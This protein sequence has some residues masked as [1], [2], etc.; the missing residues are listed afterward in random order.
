M[1][2]REWKIV[3][4]RHISSSAKI[5]GTRDGAALPYDA[6]TRMEED[7]KVESGPKNRKRRCA[8]ACRLGTICARCACSIFD[9]YENLPFQSESHLGHCFAVSSSGQPG[10]AL[11][12]S[13]Y[14]SV[15]YTKIVIPA[16]SSRCGIISSK[17]RVEVTGVVIQFLVNSRITSL[18]R[19]NF[20]S[21]LRNGR[22]DTL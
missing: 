19:L 16:L 3:R 9:S 1:G 12:S 20:G 21:A 4:E 13:P 22:K 8:A 2:L 6:R 11:F 7:S 17:R 10:D 14:R 5:G 15:A 18:C